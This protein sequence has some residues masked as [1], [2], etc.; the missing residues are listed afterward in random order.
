MVN[1]RQ[2]RRLRSPT[3]HTCTRRKLWE[4]HLWSGKY[5]GCSQGYGGLGH[6]SHH[7]GAAVFHFRTNRKKQIKM[8][9]SRRRFWL[10][11]IITLGGSPTAVAAPPILVKITSAIRTCLGSRLSTSH[12][13]QIRQGQ[14]NKKSSLASPRLRQVGG[15]K[16]RTS[17]KKKKI[18]RG[19]KNWSLDVRAVQ[20]SFVRRLF[21]LQESK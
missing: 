1:Q 14:N 19:W 20:L 6:V 5:Q 17:R 9:T 2:P 21:M 8:P 4:Q 12:N 15:S 11:T 3:V 7:G 18:F 13:L 10:D 16:Y